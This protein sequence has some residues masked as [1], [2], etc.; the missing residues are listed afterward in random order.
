MIQAFGKSQLSRCLRPVDFH[1]H[2]SIAVSEFARDLLL[3]SAYQR[4]QSGLGGSFQLLR[5][6]SKGKTTYS[7]QGLDYKLVL[8]LCSEYLCQEVES[9]PKS[10]SRI[11]REISQFL[12][13]GC[14]YRI[15][16]LD[17]ASFFESCDRSFLLESIETT[18]LAQHPRNLI[19]DLF[20]HLDKSCFPGLPRGLEVSSPLSDL[21]LQDFDRSLLTHNDVQYFA[22]FVDD[23]FV[24]TNGLEDKQKFIKRIRGM[25]PPPAF[26]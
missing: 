25:L 5:Q 26:S 15:Y 6:S 19:R 14:P 7:A 10:R 12:R 20:R 11:T 21:M 18:S 17:I 4:A 22:R 2:K 3:S 9:K 1:K 23:I 13:Q 16:K 24:I 8:R